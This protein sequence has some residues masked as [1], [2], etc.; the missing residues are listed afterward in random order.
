M[1]LLGVADLLEDAAFV[2]EGCRDIVDEEPGLRK[3]HGLISRVRSLGVVIIWKKCYKL[4][5][6]HAI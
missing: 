6:D 4:K 3:S 1:S 5:K 2:L